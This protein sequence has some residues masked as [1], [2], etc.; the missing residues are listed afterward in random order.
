[1]EGK[2]IV[3]LGGGTAGWLTALFCR[4]LFPLASITLIENTSIGTVGVGEGTTLAFM[5]FLRN[6]VDIDAFD[7]LKECRGSVKSGIS[8]ENWNG[9]NKKYFHSFG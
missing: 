8:F 1:M 4:K 5:T 2:K 6:E 7:L 9:D 3:I